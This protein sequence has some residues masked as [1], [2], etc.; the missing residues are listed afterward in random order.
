MKGKWSLSVNYKKGDIVFIND[1]L[2]N[3]HYYICAMSHTSDELINPRNEEEIY[4]IEIKNM[5]PTIINDPNDSFE[6]PPNAPI[7]SFLPEPPIY[8]TDIDIENLLSSIGIPI[9]RDP[10]S[11]T[12]IKRK[13]NQE[14]SKEELI[15]N[16]KQEK[17]K[18]KLQN[19]ENDISSFKKKEN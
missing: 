7:L 15:E 2:S 10:P 12:I 9:L 4:W 8:P 16:K 14:M 18:R 17:L 19:I 1:S 3:A 11:P 5:L 13:R 6:R